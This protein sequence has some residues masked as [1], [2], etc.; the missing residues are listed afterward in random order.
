MVVVVKVNGVVI[1]KDFY[2]VQRI[3]EM[4]RAGFSIEAVRK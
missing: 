3:K 4:E 2:T 1:D